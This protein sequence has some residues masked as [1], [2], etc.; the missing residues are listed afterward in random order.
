M[1]TSLTT[2]DIPTWFTAIAVLS[3]A[4]A[5]VCAGWVALD[6]VRRPQHMGVMN[7]VWP[8]V[9]LFGSVAW[10]AF[11]LRFGRARASAQRRGRE[12]DGDEA[13]D[14]Y[15]AHDGHEGHEGHEAPPSRTER[16]VSTATGTNHCGAGCTLG[17]VTADAVLV[18]LPLLVP[19]ALFP[20][21]IY[22]GWI[23][24]T[25]FA[26]AFGVVFQYF[27]IAPMRG[28][29]LV[30]GLLAALKADA[31][32]IAAWQVGMIG[33]MAIVQLAVLPH[34]LGGHAPPSTAA[35]WFLMQCAMVL[36]FACSY[37]VNAWLERQGI[38]ESM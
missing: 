17:D 30:P 24:G 35:Y 36:G 16:M 18:L 5:I 21:E 27:A 22:A 34:W 3:L 12:H 31:A 4:L 28:L 11:Y 38:K 25:V 20:H 2:A 15:E 7:V 37:P 33:F 1:S 32:S 29:P 9:M 6:V 26:F 23:L 10:L 14:G 19:A 8:V 13:H